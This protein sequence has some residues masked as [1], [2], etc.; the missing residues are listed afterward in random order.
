M[1]NLEPIEEK[2]DKLLSE[3]VISP[4][5]YEI[6]GKVYNFQDEGLYRVILP[7]E[8]N[9]QRIVFKEN[10]EALLSAISWIYSHGTKDNKLSYEKLKNKALQAKLV[11]TCS[12][13]SSFAQKILKENDIQARVVN[14][15]TEEER[16]GFDDSHTLIEVKIA[17]KWRVFDLDNNSYFY[18]GETPLSYLELVNVIDTGDYII[19]PLSQDTKIVIDGFKDSETGY[20]YSFYGEERLNNEASL[21]DWYSRVLDIP[22]IRDGTIPYYYQGDEKSVKT[23]YPN[24]MK[25]SEADFL[26]KF[27][28]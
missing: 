6:Y 5:K 7:P 22:F 11:T 4:G 25:I 15:L 10:S 18:Q 24:A 13:V 8:E 14:G 1:K 21:R 27:Y 19:R 28:Q 2:A 16:N 3:L 23:F 20:D 9:Q 12:V 17:D 26:E